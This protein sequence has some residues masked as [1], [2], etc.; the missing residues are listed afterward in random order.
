MDRTVRP[1]LEKILNI[2]GFKSISDLKTVI[3][4]DSFVCLDDMHVMHLVIE[5]DLHYADDARILLRP[6]SG[7]R[8]FELINRVLELYHQMIIDPIKDFDDMPVVGYRL[9]HMPAGY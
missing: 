1:S 8:K 2:L 3:P 9:E 6:L 5:Y 4:L 7:E